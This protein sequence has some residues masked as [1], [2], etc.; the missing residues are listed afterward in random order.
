MSNDFLI[1]CRGMLAEA[2]VGNC[3]AGNSF[4]KTLTFHTAFITQTVTVYMEGQQDALVVGGAHVP[5]RKFKSHPK[6]ELLGA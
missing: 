4:M 5:V 6:I 3:G 1:I 2:I